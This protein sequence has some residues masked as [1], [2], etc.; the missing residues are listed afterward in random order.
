[1]E[2]AIEENLCGLYNLVNNVS[3]SKYDLLVLFN[4]YFRNNGVA[5]R[6]DGDLKLDKS[7]R[8]KRKDFSFVVPSYEQMVQE[9]KEWVD[10]HSDL[11]P[12]YK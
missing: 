4:Q 6:K 10:A 11:Y 7:L 2:K 9:M 1:M 3:I 8:S 12:H 5:I